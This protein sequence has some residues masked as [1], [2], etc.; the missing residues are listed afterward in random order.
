MKIL[1][2]GGLGFVG[3]HLSEQLLRDGHK[4]ILLTRSYSKKI[5]SKI[6]QKKSKLKKLM[7]LIC[8]N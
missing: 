8:Q 7:S 5:T 3:S 6:L 4:L 2:T 1:I